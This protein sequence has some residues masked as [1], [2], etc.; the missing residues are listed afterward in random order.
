MQSARLI[1]CAFV[2][3][4]IQSA[5]LAKELPYIDLVKR[6]TEAGGK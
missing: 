3:L 6:L 4:A 1:V 5:G 2:V